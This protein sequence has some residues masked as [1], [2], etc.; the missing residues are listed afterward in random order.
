MASAPAGSPTTDFSGIP[1]D[2]ATRWLIA[3]AV[4]S[5]AIMELIDTSAVN[6][7][8]PYI[9]GNTAAMSERMLPT[10]ETSRYARRGCL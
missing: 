2:R 6:A 9:A 1:P 7:S 3:I 8:I 4:M 5:S 10:L